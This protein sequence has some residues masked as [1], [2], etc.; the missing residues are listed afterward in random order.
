[1]D[2]V[3]ENLTQC[4]SSPQCERTRWK[5]DLIDLQLLDGSDR[6]G[7]IAPLT[8]FGNIF[9]IIIFNLTGKFLCVRLKSWEVRCCNLHNNM[10]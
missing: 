3:F 6:T 4:K 9:F 1:M 2:V 10:Y 8:R 7:Q 5:F